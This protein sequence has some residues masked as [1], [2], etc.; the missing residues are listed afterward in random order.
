MS[1][2]LRSD[3]SKPTVLLTGAGGFTGAYVSAALHRAGYR[4]HN[5]GH[6]GGGGS[7]DTDTQES[8][9][10]TDRHA[11]IDAVSRLDLDAVIH[12]AAI[13]FVAHGDAAAI[14]GVNVLGTRNLLEA[15]GRAQKPPRHILLASSANVYGE[16]SGAIDE[17]APYAPQNDY[18]VSKMAMEQM[19]RLW[20]RSLPITFVRPF[21][22]TGLGQDERFLLPKIVAHFR[23]KAE[24][25]ELGN[26]DVWRDFSDVRRVAEAYVRLLTRPA[27]G[28]VFN[29]C[30]G[31]ELSIREAVAHLE[32]ISGHRMRIETNPAFMRANEIT[33]L[34][35]DPTKIEEAI[36]PLPEYDIADTL[37]WMY[38]GY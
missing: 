18:A 25:I 3:M 17:M 5:W 14:Y 10:L 33:H 31:R 12:L 1:A 4:V 34:H 6:I 27:N 36:G 15:L 29:I 9:D 23:R 19:A 28:D 37:R 20:S 30:S 2:G 21:N 38:E 7:A 13:S 32:H 26:I 16:K 8:I 24:L 11:V 35:G 22:Y